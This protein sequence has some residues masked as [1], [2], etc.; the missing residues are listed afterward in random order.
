MSLSSGNEL[1]GTNY[2]E[3]FNE[4]PLEPKHNPS[5]GPSSP[6]KSTRTRLL[7]ILQVTR[8]L[9]GESPHSHKS[10][11]SDITELV[12]PIDHTNKDLFENIVNKNIFRNAAKK[13]SRFPCRF[14]TLKDYQDILN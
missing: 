14:K 4:S 6:V 11:K 2:E 3:V 10:L 8:G 13:I 9:L 5:T 12:E 1:R 7:E